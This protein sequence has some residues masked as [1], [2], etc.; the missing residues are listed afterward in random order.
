MGMYWTTLPAWPKS[1]DLVMY[2]TN[3]NSFETQNP[4]DTQSQLSYSFD[5]NNP[6]PTFG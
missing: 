5:P 2:M 4:P 6:V 3:E 1:T